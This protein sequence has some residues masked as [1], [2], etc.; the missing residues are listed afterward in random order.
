MEIYMFEVKHYEN[1][2]RSEFKGLFVCSDGVEP[3]L[4]LLP[5]SLDRSKNLEYCNWFIDNTK[6][7]I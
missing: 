5:I 7:V 2:T 3:D 1:L 6:R 4:E